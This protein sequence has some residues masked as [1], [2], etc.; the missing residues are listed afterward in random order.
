MKQYSARTRQARGWTL[1][2][3]VMVLVIL[4]IVVAV[5]GRMMSSM[6]R[7]YFAAR[8]IT[9]S[10][11]QARVGFERMTRELRQIRTATAGDVD[12]ASGIQIRF[13][14]MDGNSVCYYRD[15]ATSRLMRS[16]DGPSS[17]CGTTLP[18]PLSDFVSSLN[19]YYYTSTLAATVPPPTSLSYITV[20]VGVQDN[21]VSDTL[22]ATI[23]PRTFP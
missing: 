17:A 22:R 3:V 19:F 21:D 7:S 15:V 11:A 16:A 23:H 18:Q 1:I 10:D 12:I 8:D 6:L 9:S 5:G 2:E 14:D 20:K 4:A 13:I